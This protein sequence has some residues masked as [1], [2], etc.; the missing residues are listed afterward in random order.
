MTDSREIK[1][2]ILYNFLRILPDLKKK[3][4]S[5][6]GVLKCKI[7]GEPSSSGVCGSC[8]IIERLK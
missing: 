1:K 5:K 3:Y 4:S 7:C 8:N 2:N 6:Q